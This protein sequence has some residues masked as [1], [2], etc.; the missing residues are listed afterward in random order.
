LIKQ[1]K[2]YKIVKNEEK[3]KRVKKLF[4]SYIA[5][6]SIVIF[7]ATGVAASFVASDQLIAR[8]AVK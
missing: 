7:G 2:L 3:K 5:R 4:K 8:T 6:F 1:Q